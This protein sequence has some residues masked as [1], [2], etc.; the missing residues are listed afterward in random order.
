LKWVSL[1]KRRE[2]TMKKV[3]VG[4]TVWLACRGAQACEGRQSKVVQ[5]RKVN[6][7]RIYRYRCMTCKR[8]FQIVI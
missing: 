2:G 5:I 3:E 8:L 6:G 7:S 4:D 1:Y